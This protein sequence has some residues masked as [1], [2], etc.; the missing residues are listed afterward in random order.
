MMSLHR[1]S[2][3]Q[4]KGFSLLLTVGAAENSSYTFCPEEHRKSLTPAQAGQRL[5]TWLKEDHQ[6]LQSCGINKFALQSS[7]AHR[8]VLT[9]VY[10][11]AIPRE[12]NGL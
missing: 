10:S 5:C 9:P 12:I 6:H 2:C 7:C 11:G 1:I 8:G 3:C 4:R